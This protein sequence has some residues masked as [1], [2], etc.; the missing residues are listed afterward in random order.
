[1]FWRIDWRV[2]HLV[3]VVGRPHRPPSCLYVEQTSA[4][5]TAHQDIDLGWQKTRD[6]V[7]LAPCL[8]LFVKEFDDDR[9]EH[10]GINHVGLTFQRLAA[11]MWQDI[12][13]CISG[14][15]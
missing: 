3:Q 4:S 15:V 10:V 12:S 8:V 11:G 6:V 5:K 1:M 14:M 9:G 7:H 2:R 13:Q